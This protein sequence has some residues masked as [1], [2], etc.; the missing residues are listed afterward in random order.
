[1]GRFGHLVGGAALLTLSACGKSGGRADGGGA[2]GGGGGAISSSGT[3]GSSSGGGAGGATSGAGGAVSTAG[4][5]GAPSIGGGPGACDGIDAGAAAP[6][7]YVDLDVTASGFAEHEGQPVFLLTRANG[8]RTLGAGRAIVSGGAFSFHFPKGYMRGHAQEI[9]WLLDADGD[10][11][12]D[13]AAGDHTGYAVLSAFDPPG[14]GVAAVAISDNHV[15]TTSSGAGLCVAGMG[16]GDMM[17]MN[18][19]GTGFDAHEGRTV[20]LLA[21]SAYNGAIFAAGDAIVT[22]GG[23]AFQFQRGFERFTYEEIFSFVDVDGDGRCTWGTDH[24][25]YTVTPALNPANNSPV[26]VQVMDN[27]KIQSDRGADVCVV[28][29]GCQLAP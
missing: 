4:A 29:N 24:P 19:T 16:F 11:V 20:H 17:D 2:T 18:V 15:Q 12:C 21:R 3:G 7:P 10:G 9:L 25:G 28:M 26:E 1:M 8:D 23:F 5:G 27:H 22:A 13:A 14:D 6:A